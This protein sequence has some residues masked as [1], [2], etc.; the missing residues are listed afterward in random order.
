[1][2]V[3]SALQCKKKKKKSIIPWLIQ[4]FEEKSFLG[5]I[6]KNTFSNNVKIHSTDIHALYHVHVCIMTSAMMGSPRGGKLIL[7]MNRTYSVASKQKN[8]LLTNT[9]PL[10]ILIIINNTLEGR[11]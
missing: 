11:W 5:M 1:M 4:S 2:A 6:Y 10:I 3:Q 8:C 9:L 7:C